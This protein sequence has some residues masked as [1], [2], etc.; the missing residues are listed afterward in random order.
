MTFTIYFEQVLDIERQYPYFV[1]I[2]LYFFKM[3]NEGLN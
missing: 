3:F 1:C 2:S